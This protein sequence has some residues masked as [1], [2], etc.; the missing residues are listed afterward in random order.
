MQVDA[1]VKTLSTRKSL[2]VGIAG[3]VHMHLPGRKLD[4]VKPGA[5]SRFEKKST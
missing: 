1:F 3:A 5:D 4:F 2:W